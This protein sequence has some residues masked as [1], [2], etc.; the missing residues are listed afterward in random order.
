MARGRDTD[1]C[2]LAAKV[3]FDLS[4][5]SFLCSTGTCSKTYVRKTFGEIVMLVQTFV[6]DT[7]VR[8][9]LAAKLNVRK[10][11]REIGRDLV[12]FRSYRPTITCRINKLRT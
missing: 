2:T 1:P 5:G 7:K 3:R 4:S 8:R 9:V 12:N 10:T 6:N 11:I